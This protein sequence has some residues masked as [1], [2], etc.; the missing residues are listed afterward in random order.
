M[1]ACDM[2]EIDAQFISYMTSI[3]GDYDALVPRWADEGGN[4]HMEPLHTIY[5]RSALPKLESCVS[6]GQFALHSCLQNLH[7]RFIEGAE[8]LPFKPAPILFRN[9]NSEDDWEK[10]VS[11]GS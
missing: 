2:P 4:L 9:L 7:V 8:L 1:L 10:F 11:D 5:R 3:S 6:R